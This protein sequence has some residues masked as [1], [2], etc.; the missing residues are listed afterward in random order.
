MR[1]SK[2]KYYTV[3]RISETLGDAN[4]GRLPGSDVRLVIGNAK[5]DEKYDLFFTKSAKTAYIVI[6]E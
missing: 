3:M 6:E 4:Y 2:N 5:Y 1:I